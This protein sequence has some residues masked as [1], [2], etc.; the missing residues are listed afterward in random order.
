MENT[1]SEVPAAAPAAESVTPTPN[2]N[3]TPAPAIDMHGFTTDELADMRTFLDNNG[4]WSKIKSRI[5]NPEPAPASAS[6]QIPE[7]QPN[8]TSQTQA[9]TQMSEPQFKTPAGAITQRE[10]L[11]KQYFSS[12]AHE[13]KYA[14][15]AKGI[16]NGDYLKEMAAFGINTVN[17]DNSINDDRVRMYLDLKVQTVPAQPTSTEPSASTAPLVEYYQIDGDKITDINQA[18][19]II[20]QDMRLKAKGQPGHPQ[21]ALAEEFLRSRKTK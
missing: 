19:A 16:E 5:S 7:V 11:A 3:Q 15:I 17:P 20:D 4:G 2:T 6:A 18:Y 9:P 12:L 21:V 8:P 14:P 1:P 10:F 13:E